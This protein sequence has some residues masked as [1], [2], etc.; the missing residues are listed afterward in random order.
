MQNI[1]DVSE[2]QIS[3]YLCDIT[4]VLHYHTVTPW[5]LQY[6]SV[7][8]RASE[9]VKSLVVLH[10]ELINSCI[11]SAMKKGNTGLH[12]YTEIGSTLSQAKDL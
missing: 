12:T 5:F 4:N 2:Y 3:P 10:E 8:C 9:W 7:T 1:K 6:Y 11:N